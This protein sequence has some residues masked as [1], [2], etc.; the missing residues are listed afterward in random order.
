MS[1]EGWAGGG[2][3]GGW[4]K[5]WKQNAGNEEIVNLENIILLISASISS[6]ATETHR[7]DR[8]A[9][10]FPSSLLP[11]VPRRRTRAVGLVDDARRDAALEVDVEDGG[12]VGRLGG[13]RRHAEHVRGRGVGGVLEDARLVG[14]VHHVLVHALGLRLR[15]DDGHAVRGRL[16]EEV[17]AAAEAV[18]EG[19]VA[20]GHDGL[21]RGVE[22]GEGE[23]EADLVVALARRAVRDELAAHLVRDLDGAA[24]DAGAREGGPHELK[25]FVNA[26][27]L[28]GREDEVVEEV[29]PEV[30]DVDGLGADLCGKWK[31]GRWRVGRGGEGRQE[32]VKEGGERER[33]RRIEAAG[34]SAGGRGG[35]RPIP[36]LPAPCSSNRR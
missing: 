22:R 27:R 5:V 21:E 9:A 29:R 2:W 1:A 32:G 16:L 10:L 8:R 7:A 3:V 35:I 30:L 15:L 23:L 25:V 26:I 33:A 24:R 18:L 36:F 20:P 14:D 34:S 6:V 31:R 11:S 19:G 4:V 17:R 28:D 13:V 12:R